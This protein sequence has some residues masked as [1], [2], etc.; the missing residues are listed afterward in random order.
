MIYRLVPSA[1]PDSYRDEP[2]WFT[3]LQ[4]WGRPARLPPRSLSGSHLSVFF[5]K[6]YCYFRIAL[7]E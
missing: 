5:D 2:A 3:V 1:D 6:F 7:T 4:M